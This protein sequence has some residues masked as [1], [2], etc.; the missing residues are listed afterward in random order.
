MTFVR[1][2]NVFKNPKTGYV[3]RWTINHTEESEVQNSRQ[4]ADGAPTSDIGLLPQ[5]G[6][7]LPIVFQWK[8]T[9]F[10][11]LE[12]DEFMAWWELCETQTIYL[13]DFSL[14]QYEILITDFNYQRKAVA[15][16]Q[17]GQIPWLWTYTITIR[18]L[19]TFSGELL[20]RTP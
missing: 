8:G 14:S 11:Q 20:F 1:N 16:N 5:Q 4:M 7:P 10:T 13:Q 6:V 19:K 17:R 2:P 9:I 3:F 18:V 15:W 12:L